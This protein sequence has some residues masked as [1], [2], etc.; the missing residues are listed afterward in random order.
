MTTFIIETTQV[1]NVTY[2]VEADTPAEAWES[3]LMGFSEPRG[4]QEPGDIV[5]TFDESTITVEPD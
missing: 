1:F 2:A 3:L 4:G 5:G